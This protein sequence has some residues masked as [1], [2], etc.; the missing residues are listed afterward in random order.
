MCLVL[1]TRRRPFVVQLLSCVWLFPV[2]HHLWEFG[3]THVH[4]VSDAIQ[5][6]HP[7]LKLPPAF[8]LSQH[9]GLF[10][11]VGSFHQ[12]AK[13]LEIQ[14]QQH[15]SNEYLGLICFRIDWFVVRSKGLFKS[16][17][18]HHILKTSVLW[19]SV[20][21]MLQLLNLYRTTGKTI[22]LT[23]W[24]FVGQGQQ[25]YGETC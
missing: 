11:W 25:E 6:S 3:Q 17:L 1:L 7:L 20:I 21:F 8:Y 9:H 15:T 23:I 5:Q 10:Q 13:V 4:L 14:L 12:V 16:L 22:V 24:T 19:Y 18:Q 2:L